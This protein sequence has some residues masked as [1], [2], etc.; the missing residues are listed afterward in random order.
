MNRHRRERVDTIS[1]SAAA[2]RCGQGTAGTA[3][4]RRRRNYAMTERPPITAADLFINSAAREAGLTDGFWFRA[5]NLYMEEVNSVAGMSFDVFE[6]AR[7]VRVPFEQGHA[8]VLVRSQPES[9]EVRILR[10]TAFAA[11]DEAEVRQV[12]RLY[13]LDEDRPVLGEAVLPDDNLR[14]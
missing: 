13:W 9:R 8:D 5:Y 3:R 2:S 4:E 12:D 11:G 10:F 14:W 1:K 6:M 7:T